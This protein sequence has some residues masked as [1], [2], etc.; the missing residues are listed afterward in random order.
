MLIVLGLYRKRLI[1]AW[2]DTD[3]G[4]FIM[5][6][7]EGKLAQPTRRGKR[8]INYSPGKN[9]SQIVKPQQGGVVDDVSLLQ[10]CGQEMIDALCEEPRY[11]KRLYKH[12]VA[13][14]EELARQDHTSAADKFEKVPGTMKGLEEEWVVNYLSSISDLSSDLIMKFRRQDEKVAYK[15][16]S[17]AT[18][19]GME[20]PLAPCWQYKRFAKFALDSLH[21]DNGRRMAR[22]AATHVAAGGKINWNGFAYNVVVGEQSLVSIVHNGS[23]QQ[24]E[25][26][27]YNIPRSVDIKWPWMDQQASFVMPPM[28]PTKIATFFR[29]DEGPHVMRS[30]V[31]G[32][33]KFDDW[34]TTKFTEWK[35]QEG[36]QETVDVAPS[37]VAKELHAQAAK[38]R[39]AAMVKARAKAAETLAKKQALMMH[40]VAID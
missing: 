5:A 11:V 21:T 23:A 30:F 34:T 15:L 4:L 2:R 7:G 1:V 13:I 6:V 36:P 35:D 14:K 28:K 22:F 32:S 8:T 40:K 39:D 12:F 16:L 20:L 37:S 29:K 33:K 17:A 25:V 3:A 27:N 10:S 24:V 26:A 38:K 9:R 19:L 18:Q 31:Y